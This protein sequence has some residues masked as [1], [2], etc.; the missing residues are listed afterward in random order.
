MPLRRGLR[1]VVKLLGHHLACALL[2]SALII[3]NIA[4]NSAADPQKA[5]R[6]TPVLPTDT[7]DD[8]ANMGDTEM[9]GNLRGFRKRW[10]QKSGLIRAAF[11]V[12]VL[13]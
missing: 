12:T 7:Y 4:M 8:D 1:T 3:V 10:S 2:L 6:T 9:V 5:T 11:H 13:Q